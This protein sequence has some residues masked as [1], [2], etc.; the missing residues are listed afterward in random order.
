[1]FVI[2]I[3]MS[4]PP[5]KTAS[6]TSGPSRTRVSRGQRERRLKER[7]RRDLHR[8]RSA[9]SCAASAGARDSREQE[10]AHGWRHAHA[11]AAATLLEICDG[12]ERS[13]VATS[14]SSTNA[15]KGAIAAHVV[16]DSA[17]QLAALDQHLGAALSGER[18][19]GERHRCV[20]LEATAA[21]RLALESLADRIAHSLRLSAKRALHGALEANRGSSE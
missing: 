5:S 15:H 10:A 18:A 3:G 11:H 4:A 12:H 1:M 9:N 14:R 19:R 6:E 16:D 17:Q 8:A 7:A 2:E 21:G 13:P 20:G